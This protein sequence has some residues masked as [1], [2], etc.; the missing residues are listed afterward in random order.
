MKLGISDLK[1][2]VVFVAR[3]QNGVGKA[4]VDQGNMIKQAWDLVPAFRALPAAV[5]GSDQVLPQFKDLDEAEKTELVE[6]YKAELD[7]PQDVIEQTCEM[8]FDVA[9]GFLKLALEYKK[10]AVAA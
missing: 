1:D 4:I 10:A 8:A 7:L 3:A 6:I 5:A 9:I 2:W